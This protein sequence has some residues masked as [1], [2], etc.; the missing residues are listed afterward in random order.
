MDNDNLVTRVTDEL[1]WDPKVDN[2]EIAVSADEGAV[3]LRGTVGSLRQKREAK[4]D[5]EGVYGVRSVKDEL[6]VR[7][8][9]SERRD[10][11]ELRGRVLQAMMLN[12]LVPT[13]IDASVKDGVVT[14][15]G[16]ANWQYQREAAE[17][18]AANIL[19]AVEVIDEVRLEVMAK[20]ADVKGSITK[21]LERSA[22]V[23]ADNLSV[24]TYN[25]SVT[26]SGTVGSWAEHDAVIAAAW[27]AP[28][29]TSIDD[30][31]LV[32]Y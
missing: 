20:S 5:A 11:A 29:V 7:V 23:Q 25:G 21:A 27:S 8:L 18:T 1:F 28:G 30:L 10:D 22:K 15:T 12:S 17:D 16:T 13:T 24:D 19:G 4:K 6:S 32:D 9:T 14:L 26:I 3:T 2:A 31:V